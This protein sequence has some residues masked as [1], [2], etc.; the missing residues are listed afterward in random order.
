MSELAGDFLSLTASERQFAEA[1][2][3]LAAGRYG[4]LREAELRGGVD[5]D[6]E[7]QRLLEIETAY[8]ANARIITA[9]EEMLDQLMRI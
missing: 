3:A 9:V 5:T 6:Q 1:D 8:A 4:T 7:L 2:L